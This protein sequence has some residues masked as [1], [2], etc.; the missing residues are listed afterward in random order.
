MLV[1]SAELLHLPWHVTL[2]AH[3]YNCSYPRV[4]LSKCRRQLAR[5]LTWHRRSAWRVSSLRITVIIHLLSG[6]CL[7]V[8]SGS[9][10]P[11][12]LPCKDKVTA[13]AHLCDSTQPLA[14]ANAWCLALS[15]R[16]PQRTW[17]FS[18]LFLPFFMYQ[19]SVEMP[20]YGESF[21]LFS[22]RFLVDFT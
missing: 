4:V 16:R 10:V 20:G 3:Q 13:S 8:T 18:G 14:G 9:F 17:G 21:N 7:A 6:G 2:S 5:L 22:Y 1:D 11:G 19:I 15:G 12:T